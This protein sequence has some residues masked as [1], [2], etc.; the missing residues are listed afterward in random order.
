MAAGQKISGVKLFELGWQASR[1]TVL[2]EDDHLLRRF[3]QLDLVNL[4]PGIC[5]I[6]HRKEGADEIWALVNGE[7]EVQLSDAREESPTFQLS[8]QISLSVDP[9][10]AVLIPFGLSAEISSVHGGLLLRVSSHADQLFPDD[11]LFDSK[12]KAG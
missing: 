1:L 11:L 10:V 7:A 2:N 3:G 8:M 4:E 6:T 5:L 9:P 12:N